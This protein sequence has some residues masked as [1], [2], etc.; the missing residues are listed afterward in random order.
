MA[1]YDGPIPINDEDRLA[2]WKWIKENGL[3]QGVG[4]EL[5]GPMI[6][7]R[8]FGGAAKPEWITDI[9]SGRRT[10]FK[11]LTLDAWRKQY[12]QRITLDNAINDSRRAA[13][14]PVAKVFDR[15][16]DVPRAVKVAYHFTVF[17]FTHSGDLMY[18][19]SEYKIWV[20]AVMDSY[21]GAFSEAHA[22]LKLADIEN[23]I[24]EGREM[25]PMAIQAGLDAGKGSHPVGLLSKYLGSEMSERS[26]K[27]L[28][29]M[30]Y[31][32]W[33]SQVKRRL[34]AD[35]TPEE[36]H[37]MAS[38]YATWANNATGSGEG[39]I[40]QFGSKV[41]FG[42]K[43]TQSKINRLVV[44][45]YNTA[46]TFANWKTATP[47]QK[48]IAWT[49]LSGAT[50][51]VATKLVFLAI[52]EAVLSYFKSKQKINYTD[53]NKGDYLEFKALGLEGYMPG[54]QTEIRTLAKMVATGFM[55]SKELRGKS[56]VGH[57]GEV[58]AQ[59]GMGKMSPTI[60]LGLE[61]AYRQDYWGRPVPW[62]GEK[63]TKKEPPLT[64]G[65][66][67]GE[68]GPLPLEGPVGYVYDHLRQNGAS[69]KESLSITKALII[70]GL[71]GMGI[72]VQEEKSAK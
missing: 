62:S 32:L 48:A 15:I 19:P 53:P 41:M 65:E 37:D 1:C 33:E 68:L 54:L 29:V 51:Y 7:E 38:E 71:G 16:W 55:A 43:L 46:K 69:A 50:Q 27:M 10:P 52:N 67:A 8:F 45:P 11:Q 59:W 44:D 56:R 30:R 28:T 60:E 25:F 14:G 20:K 72:H 9:L 26:W 12:R 40:A 21:L 47:A 61:T 24:I 23:R 6:N 3:D 13:M 4:I 64:W 39:K 63:G 17:P 58:L 22:G 36:V 66:Y 5:T 2:I 42:P 49:R 18:R 31:E 70:F 35:M 57:A 34:R